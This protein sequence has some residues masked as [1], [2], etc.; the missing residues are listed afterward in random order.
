[1]KKPKEITKDFIESYL[2][3]VLKSAYEV[4]D[5]DF[6]P[7]VKALMSKVSKKIYKN[8]LESIEYQIQDLDEAGEDGDDDYN[9]MIDKL[10]GNN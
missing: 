10:L 8:L 3:D 4:S 2:Q 7:E 1:M 5:E 6:T 9:D